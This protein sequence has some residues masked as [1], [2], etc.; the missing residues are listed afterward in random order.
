MGNEYAFVAV[1]VAGVLLVAWRLI[2]EPDT[3][4]TGA[5]QRDVRDTNHPEGEAA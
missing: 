3:G 1:L 2:A 5:L 4:G